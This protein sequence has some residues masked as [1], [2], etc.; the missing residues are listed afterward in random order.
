MTEDIVR[1][2]GLTTLGSRLRRIGE[3]LQGEVQQLFDQY[4]F[5]IQPFQYPL[6]LALYEGG[7]LEIGQISKAL[8]VSQPGVTRS[9]GQ[10]ATSGCVQ[11]T[12]DENDRRVRRVSLTALGRNTVNEVQDKIAPDVIAG[13]HEIL[14]VDAHELLSLLG[15]LEDGLDSG[16][17]AERAKR[18]K[19]D[20]N[21]D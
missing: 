2:K 12:L 13:F 1:S 21:H 3:R 11:V 4:E 17:F 10:L 15:R 5:P 8:G 18:R 19:Q 16:S 9:V 20:V 7:A 14:D 6:L